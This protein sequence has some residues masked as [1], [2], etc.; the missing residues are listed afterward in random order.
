MRQPRWRSV[1][2]EELRASGLTPRNTQEAWSVKP[3]MTE[4]PKWIR[5][6]AIPG[7]ANIGGRIWLRVGTAK[8]LIALDESQGGTPEVTRVEYKACLQC[9]RPIIG[10]DATEYRHRVELKPDWPCGI[11]CEKDRLSGLW[12]TLRHAAA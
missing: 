6:R 10:G 9:F 5:D 11:N 7:L 4:I 8:L 12:N 2:R 1:R 3:S